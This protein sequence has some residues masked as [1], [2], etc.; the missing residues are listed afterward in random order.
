[1]SLSLSASSFVTW[2]DLEKNSKTI[3]NASSYYYFFSHEI[4]LSP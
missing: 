1:M 4:F 2:K 3:N